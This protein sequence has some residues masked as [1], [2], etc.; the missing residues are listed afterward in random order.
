MSARIATALEPA[1]A[2]CRLLRANVAANDLDDRVT[3]VQLALS[4]QPGTHKLEIGPDNAGIVNW[5]KRNGG[6]HPTKY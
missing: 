4:D 2:N 3:I 6:S 1:E 5:V